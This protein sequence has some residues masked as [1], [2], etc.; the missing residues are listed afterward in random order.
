MIR[1]FGI[2]LFEN[3]SKTYIQNPYT[4]KNLYVMLDACHMLK[5]IRNMLADLVTDDQGNVINWQYIC[6]LVKIQDE[7]GL[8]AATKLRKRHIDF[9]NEKMKVN[10]AAQT[11]SCS[12]SKALQFCEQDLK[13]PQFTGAFGTSRFCQIFNDIF[14]LLN[15]KNLYNKKP[16]KQ[17]ITN[18]NFE[19]IKE[20]VN[21]YITNIEQL[22]INNVNI[23]QTSRKVPF[24]N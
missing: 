7:Q 24:F 19:Q 12:T 8:H 15:S 10:L 5:L 22:K 3:N 4:K 20:K 17:G 21:S 14:D 23:L 18:T 13:L 11:L 1:N 9:R 16:T 6:E 2:N